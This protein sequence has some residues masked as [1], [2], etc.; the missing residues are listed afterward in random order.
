MYR[1]KAFR[2]YNAVIVCLAM[3]MCNYLAAGPTVA[4]VEITM[5][6]F[7]PELYPNFPAN[8]AKIAF[9]FTSSSLLQGLGNLVWMPL[10]VKYGRRPVYILSFAL[11]TATAIWAGTATSY[12]NELAAR[13]VLGFASGSGE[14]LVSVYRLAM[15]SEYRDVSKVANALQAPL[16]I[17]D[18]FFLHERGTIMA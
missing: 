18:I 9:F 1:S 6:F 10:I 13:I 3:V 12:A 7:P 8:I 17:A 4:I 5:D 15:S 16:T 11:Y 14:C 2:Y